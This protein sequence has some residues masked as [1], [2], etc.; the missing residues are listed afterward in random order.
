MEQTELDG[1]SSYEIDQEIC[2]LE[3]RLKQAITENEA[4]EHLLHRLQ[5][6]W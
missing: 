3:N 5:R 2:K 6:P 4:I 1:L